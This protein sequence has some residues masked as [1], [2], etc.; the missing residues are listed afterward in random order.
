MSFHSGNSLSKSFEDDVAPRL[1]P[2]ADGDADGFEIEAVLA[3]VLLGEF[4][5]ER[6]GLRWVRH[7]ARAAVLSRTDGDG[8]R[9]SCLRRVRPRSAGESFGEVVVDAQEHEPELRIDVFVHHRR[10]GSTTRLSVHRRSLARA[11]TAICHKARACEPGIMP[12]CLTRLRAAIERLRSA[13]IARELRHRHVAHRQARRRQRREDA[14]VALQIDLRHLVPLVPLRRHPVDAAARP[15]AHAVAADA[16]I[17][18]VGDEHAAVRRHAHVDWAGT[19]CPCRWSPCPRAP[20]RS[21]PPSASGGSSA[22][23]AGR[24]RCAA[25]GPSTSSAAASPR[26]RTCRSGEPK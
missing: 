4:V 12:S 13:F 16:G 24:R 20:R 22:R 7:R 15:V 21:R 6:L 19:S 26:R 1:V 18:P 23:G 3:V 17:V 11:A 10:N 9:V 2:V 25:A 5:D 8:Y 14:L